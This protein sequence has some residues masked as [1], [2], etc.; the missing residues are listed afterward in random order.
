MI[1]GFKKDK[2]FSFVRIRNKGKILSSFA[3]IVKEKF[4]NF[5]SIVFSLISFFSLFLLV[6]KPSCSKKFRNFCLITVGYVY[7]SHVFIHMTA[8][9]TLP[10]IS[11]QIPLFILGILCLFFRKKYERVF[12]KLRKVNYIQYVKHNKILLGKYIFSGIS[13]MALELFLFYFLT[14]S[15]YLDPILSSNISLLL[16][17][18]FNYFLSRFWVF[19][20]TRNLRREII[21][22]ALIFFISLLINNAIF[23][24]CFR[25]L[26]LTPLISKSS[27]ILIST[28]FNFLT[29]KYLVFRDFSS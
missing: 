19:E 9:Y 29:K 18:F 13:S 17:G 25:F 21:L 27:A 4:F 8:N 12:I 23:I 5:L 11:V 15:F 6:L 7:L 14:N 20:K 16:A 10:I 2:N 26:M 24:F 28:A 3:L 22:F 1:G